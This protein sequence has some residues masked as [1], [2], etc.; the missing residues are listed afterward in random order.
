VRTHSFLK[1]KLQKTAENAKSTLKKCASAQFFEIEIA[2][3]LWLKM[4][5]VSCLKNKKSLVE[6]E[7]SLWLKLQKVS[8]WGK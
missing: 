7:K 4:Q 1:W 3:S 5:K 2:K 8:G 6:I